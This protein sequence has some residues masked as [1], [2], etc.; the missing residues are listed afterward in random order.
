MDTTHR[1]AFFVNF[2]QIRPPQAHLALSAELIGA[3]SDLINFHLTFENYELLTTASS[4]PAGPWRL[5][6][7]LFII[8]HNSGMNSDGEKMPLFSRL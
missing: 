3:H 6:L 7:C 5:I 1:E 2:A 8:G 4:S